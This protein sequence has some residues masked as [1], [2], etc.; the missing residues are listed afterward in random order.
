VK[1]RI[2][3]DDAPRG[4][5]FICQLCDYLTQVRADAGSFGSEES[6]AEFV[7]REVERRAREHFEKEHGNR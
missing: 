7:R 5:L 2:S 4:S 1:V 3:I 6:R